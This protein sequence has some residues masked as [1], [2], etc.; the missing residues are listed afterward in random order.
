MPE[1]TVPS[2]DLP[3]RTLGPL[4]VS[5]IGLG[6]NNFGGRVDLAGTR[7]VVDAALESGV[8]L[9]DTADIYGGRGGSERLLGEVLAGRRERVVLATKFGM[10]MQGRNGEPPGGRGSRAYIRQAVQ[11][12][13]RRLGTDWIDLYQ[14]HEPDGETPIEETL[15]ALHELVKDGI[16]RAIGASNF[17]AAQ[18]V[19]AA[20][21]AEECGFIPFV[22]V[23]NEYNLLERGIE[24]EVVPA[25]QQLG[26]GV[27]P[28]FPL[29]SGLLTGKY[30]SGEPA[31][32]GTRLQ[33][34]ERIA[35]AETFER[36]ARAERF[37]AQHGVSVLDVAIAGLANQPAVVSVIAGATKPEQLRAN[38]GALRWTPTP[39]DLRELDE[40]FPPGR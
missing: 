21:V 5:V 14:Y 23:Q 40:I 34:R 10:D 27:L 19:E 15:G 36:L 31:P 9:F 12:S 25:A 13:L 20:R 3:T 18:L 39:E 8:T 29:A 11:A 22:S 24:A 33:G 37:A 35:D 26:V 7:A 1:T 17:S 30:R 4:E 2:T 32:A 16:V 38:V 28:F 6:C